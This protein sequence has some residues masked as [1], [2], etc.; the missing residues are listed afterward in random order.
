[1]DAGQE[2]TSESTHQQYGSKYRQIFSHKSVPLLAI[3]TLIYIGVEV[4]L[5]G[6]PCFSL[7]CN[8]LLTSR[9]S[10]GWIVTFVIR[11]RGG[12][13]NSGYISSGFFGGTPIFILLDTVL[14]QSFIFQNLNG[15][16]RPHYRTPVLDVAQQNCR[17]IPHCDPLRSSCDRVSWF[18]L[19]ND[20]M[21]FSMD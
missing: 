6:L 1:M 9:H 12:G 19:F 8:F 17:G 16:H 14:R 20:W 5:G 18:N 2:P 4:T 21:Y 13:N 3:F 10:P 7:N 11:K 15:T